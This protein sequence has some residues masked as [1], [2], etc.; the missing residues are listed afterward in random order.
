MIISLVN[1]YSG[2]SRVKKTPGGPVCTLTKIHQD[3]CRKSRDIL[4]F[5]MVNLQ[6]DG[7]FMIKGV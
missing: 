4:T 6:G 2:F 1:P 7:I 3:V 5:P